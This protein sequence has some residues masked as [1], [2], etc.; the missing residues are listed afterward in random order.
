MRNLKRRFLS[1]L[2][3]FLS[4]I[5]TPFSNLFRPNLSSKVHGDQYE[6]YLKLVL[7]GGPFDTD[8]YQYKV[9]NS[10]S[11][12]QSSL[13]SPNV[14]LLKTVTDSIIEN[15]DLRTCIDLGSGT[16]WVS[17]ILSENFQ[18][19]IAIEPSSSAIE[20]AK[21][22]FGPGLASNI[23]WKQGPAEVVLLEL[24]DL[25]GP[26][27]VFTGVVLS[28]TPEA[29]AKKILKYINEDLALGSAGL[30]NEAWGN[31]RRESLWHIR[32]KAWWQEN[33]S[34]CELDFYG[35]ERENMPGEFLGLK[36]KKVR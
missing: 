25:I 26:V 19:V 33:L 20:I 7:A 13:K 5:Y 22:Y 17:N 34:N 15:P 11:F 23:E 16:G 31:P 27:F 9:L 2:K 18:R 4:Q 29:I 6:S 3:I 12:M 21:Y 35:S 28:H 8:S 10:R 1:P 36:F 30:L 14:P 24:D 32:S